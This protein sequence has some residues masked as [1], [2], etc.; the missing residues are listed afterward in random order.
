MVEEAA[1]QRQVDVIRRRVD[2]LAQAG[3]VDSASADGVA[4]EL[5]LQL[6][7][8]LRGEL[9]DEDYDREKGEILD[10]YGL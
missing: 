8:H 5:R 7:R 9:T 3:A 1:L 2:L 10:R 6:D 4:A